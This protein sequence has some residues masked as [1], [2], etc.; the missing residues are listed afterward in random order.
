LIVQRERLAI[1][2]E[3]VLLCLCDRLRFDVGATTG[4]LWQ[5]AEVIAARRPIPSLGGTQRSAAFSS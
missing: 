3:V 1:E 5:I 2:R 4:K